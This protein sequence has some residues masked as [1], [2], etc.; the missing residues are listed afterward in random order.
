MEPTMSDDRNILV[1]KHVVKRFGGL[2]AVNNMNV[3][4]EKGRIV[5]I[6]GPNGAGKTTFFNAISG[7][8]HCEEGNI[9]S[10]GGGS[11]RSSHTRSPNCAWPAPSRTSAC[12]AA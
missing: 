6:I 12:S 2:T 4:I 5:S 7:L 1:A 10:R 11:R 9:E 3:Q 8:Y